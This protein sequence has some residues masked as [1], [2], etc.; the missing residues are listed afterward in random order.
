MRERVTHETNFTQQIL[1]QKLFPAFFNTHCKNNFVIS[2]NKI[3][4]GAQ[5]IVTN[6][7]FV[8]MTKD[9]NQQIYCYYHKMISLFQHKHFVYINVQY[10]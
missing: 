7:L 3:C 9:T 2:T 5:T 6:T 8:K 10:Y 1:V 4:C